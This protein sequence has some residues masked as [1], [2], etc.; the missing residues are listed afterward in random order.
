MILSGIP[1]SAH[2]YWLTWL[3][4]PS[5]CDVGVGI[6]EVNPFQVKKKVCVCVC[7][8]FGVHTVVCIC[9]SF[10]HARVAVVQS[11]WEIICACLMSHSCFVRILCCSL[12]CRLVRIV[13]VCVCVC[14]VGDCCRMLFYYLCA[15]AAF[16]FDYFNMLV[17][18]WTMSF[19]S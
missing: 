16:G 13:G 5:V 3:N 10:P 4:C 17:F 8:R 19:V 11:I 1:G 2:G 18:D 14:V 6:P 7:V 15:I 9:I 12:S